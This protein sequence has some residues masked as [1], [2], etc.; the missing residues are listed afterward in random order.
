[1]L[2]ELEELVIKNRE[3][4]L[5][6]AYLIETNNM[7]LALK[8]LK[9]VIKM[10]N[11]KETYSFN[12]T[13]C[14]LCNLINKDSLPS[15]KII[16]PNGISIKKEQIETLKDSFSTIPIYSRYNTYIVKNAEKLNAS[17]ANSMLKFVEEPTPG[18]L[19]FFLT[20]NKDVMIDTIKSRCQSI[21]LN[22]E[23]TNEEITK[24]EY[25]NYKNTALSYLKKIN[26]KELINN[27]KELLN[28]YS[29][30]KDIEQILKIILNIYYE[31]L[32]KA[33]GL[34]YNQNL[35]K[36][37]EI[38]DTPKII[39]RKL[40]IITNILQDMSYNVNIELILDKFVIEMRGCNE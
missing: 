28:N 6:H 15:L 4:K 29:E 30:K 39:I 11:C 19:G 7:T 16:E 36:A 27:K 24:E 2:K 12:C 32:L 8:D 18:I 35:V 22:Y 14:N 38:E 25:E 23:E 5:A 26:S 34:E 10:L 20:N 13:K 1:M 40:N 31:N 9:E 33:S 37:F 21:I 3:G 17:S